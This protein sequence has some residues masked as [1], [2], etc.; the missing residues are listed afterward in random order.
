MLNANQIVEKGL[1]KLENSKGK[2]AQVGYDLSLKEVKVHI[3]STLII[4]TRCTMMR[5]R[6]IKD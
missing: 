1:L 2:K 3:H 4:T 5:F 6:S